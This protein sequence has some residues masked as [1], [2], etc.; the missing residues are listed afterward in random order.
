MN[1]WNLVLKTDQYYYWK[2][3]NGFYNCTKAETPP[4]NNTGGYYN[5]DYLIGVKND[6]VAVNKIIRSSF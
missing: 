2:H 3:T 1:K 6:R 4:S 5:L